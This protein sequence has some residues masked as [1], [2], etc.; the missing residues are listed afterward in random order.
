MMDDPKLEPSL[1]LADCQLSSPQD[2]L[3]LSTVVQK[4]VPKLGR[5]ISKWHSFG[6]YQQDYPH[7]LR[8]SLSVNWSVGLMNM[9]HGI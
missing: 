9:D 4:P 5:D 6:I 1:E 3:N 2:H 8:Q 7:K